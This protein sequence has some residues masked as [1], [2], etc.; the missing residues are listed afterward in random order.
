MNKRNHNKENIWRTKIKV[1]VLAEYTWLLSEKQTLL[2]AFKVNRSKTITSKMD[3]KKKDELEEIL[4]LNSKFS[5]WIVW[6]K[7]T[8]QAAERFLNVTKST[9]SPN[10]ECLPEQYTVSSG[11]EN[12]RN[13][14]KHW[15]LSYG[16]NYQQKKQ[17]KLNSE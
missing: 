13:R 16:I 1:L 8:S 17:T 12:G 11:L 7:L 14:S 3:E 15:A 5:E 4:C 6:R 2:L 10:P 9:S